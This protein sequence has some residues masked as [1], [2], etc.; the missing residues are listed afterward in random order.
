[1]VRV[2]F[3]KFNAL[4]GQNYCDGSDVEVWR[5]DAAE[6]C[7]LVATVE[8]DVVN[9]HSHGRVYTPKVRAYVVTL[10]TEDAPRYGDRYPTLKAARDAVRAAVAAGKV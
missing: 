1:M 3:G 7:R 10:Y 6:D 5:G 8:R 2:T 9:V 4:T